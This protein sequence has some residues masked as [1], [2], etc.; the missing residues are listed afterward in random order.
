[1]LGEILR[2]W[3]GLEPIR[4]DVCEVLRLQL[5]ESNRERK[6]LLTKLLNPTQSEPL[7]VK[8]EEP[9]PIRPQVIPWKVR[10]Q[11]LESEDRKQAQLM[12]DKKREIEELE[13]ELG[14]DHNK[15]PLVVRLPDREKEEEDAG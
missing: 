10:Q 6:E 15:E 4:C 14:I 1:M 9:Q 13:K 2:K 7:S 8:E 11:M 5:D 12:R 3:F